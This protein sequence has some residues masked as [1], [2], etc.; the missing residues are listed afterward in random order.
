MSNPRVNVTRS[1]KKSKNASKQKPAEE[2]PAEEKP[3]EEKPAEE[4][5]AEKVDDCPPTDESEESGDKKGA[6]DK[7]SSGESDSE[8]DSEDEPKKK[9]KKKKKKKSSEEEDSEESD[10]GESDSEQEFNRTAGFDSIDRS[11]LPSEKG[12]KFIYPGWSKRPVESVR[13][14]PLNDKAQRI[15]I[16]NLIAESIRAPTLTYDILRRTKEANPWMNSK[17]FISVHHLYGENTKGNP[18][19]LY[20]NMRIFKSP[21]SAYVTRSRSQ[22][23]DWRKWVLEDGIT[24]LQFRVNPVHLEVFKEIQEEL[25]SAPVEPETRKKRTAKK[26]E[27]EEGSE[28]D[29]APKK[30]KK[31]TSPK[32]EKKSKKSRKRERAKD[33]DSPKSLKKVK[34]AEETP[35]ESTPPVKIVQQAL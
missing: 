7:S 11:E 24:I 5:P 3:A 9:K 22:V 2:K 10:S 14:G 28:E 29:E 34:F 12:K 21:E 18:R 13:E 15:R 8:Q 23:I 17:E 4:K 6:E 16:R 30:K 19:N 31:K 27:L 26:A 20:N 25:A 33:G 35:E 1:P 32:K